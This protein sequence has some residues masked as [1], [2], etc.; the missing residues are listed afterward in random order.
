MASAASSAT[1]S[2][3]AFNALHWIG[4]VAAIGASIWYWSEFSGP[5]RWLVD[6]Q[7]ALTG[8]YY[9]EPLAMALLVG[10]L[11]CGVVLVANVLDPIARRVG[12]KH[13]VAM[14]LVVALGVSGAAL[15]R[16]WRLWN[17]PEVGAT[18]KYP[19]VRDLDIDTL[20]TGLLPPSRVHVIGKADPERQ[21]RLRQE[22]RGYHLYQPVVGLKRPGAVPVVALCSDRHGR[23]CFGDRLD[24]W[25]VPNGVDG[26]DLYRLRRA[27]LLTAGP[28]YLLIPGFP[29]TDEYVEPGPGD[30]GE[31]VAIVLFTALIWFTVVFSWIKTPRSP[32]SAPAPTVEAAAPSPED[33]L[34]LFALAFAGLVFVFLSVL[35]ILSWAI[36]SVF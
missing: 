30:P 14:V 16:A 17:A 23:D 25:L 18:H 3:S 9:W 7:V 13:W 6:L 22:P 4:G 11:L 33:N 1:R 31:A 34:Y 35:G 21:V 20:G 28:H 36:R 29:T 32:A 26:R 15:V 24:G 8:R 2:R 5:F 27:G 19:P 12:T 10:A